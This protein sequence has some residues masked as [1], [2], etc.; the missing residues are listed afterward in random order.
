MLFVNCS[1][2][3]CENCEAKTA[4]FALGYKNSR[5]ASRCR[6]IGVTVPLEQV[7]AIYDQYANAVSAI[8]N[9][10]SLFNKLS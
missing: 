7:D 3:P 8:F 4:K 5:F 6:T 1:I 9:I 2:I 10:R